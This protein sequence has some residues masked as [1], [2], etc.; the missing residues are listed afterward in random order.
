MQGIKK[1]KVRRGKMV[2]PIDF[3]FKDGP[4]EEEEPGDIINRGEQASPGSLAAVHDCLLG[5]R[6][7]LHAAM[8]QK[9]R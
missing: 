9:Y 7:M 5:C 8:P 2:L 4:S 1:D 3:K 6:V